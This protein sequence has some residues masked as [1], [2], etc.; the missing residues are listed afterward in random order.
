MAPSSERDSK[1]REQGGGIQ[2]SDGAGTFLSSLST[3][4]LFLLMLLRVAQ[5]LKR[6]TFNIWVN[7]TIEIRD[8]EI[9]API[10]FWEQS[11]SRRQVYVQY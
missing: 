1:Q 10:A 9:D 4:L 3:V 5:K 2:G 6:E 7:H 8:R 11:D